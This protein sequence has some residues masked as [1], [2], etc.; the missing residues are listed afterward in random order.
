MFAS[1]AAAAGSP[2]A[3]DAL[4]DCFV[5]NDDYF[6]PVWAGLPVALW[7]DLEHVYIEA[8]LPGVDEEDVDVSVEDSKVFIRGE[9]NPEECGSYLYDGRS[10]GPFERVISLPETVDSGQAEVWLNR[11]VLH[12]ALRKS[13]EAVIAGERRR[14][15]LTPA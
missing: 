6:S 14:G 1:A 3:S 2:P 4:F 7:E 5:G 11:G 15:T 12:I 8:D 9:R 10:Y 13:P